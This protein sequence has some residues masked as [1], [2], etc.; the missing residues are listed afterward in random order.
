MSYS[1]NIGTYFSVFGSTGSALEEA[2]VENIYL[3][4]SG[5]DELYIGG[6]QKY[7]PPC[8]TLKDFVIN[9]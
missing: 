6:I 3:D 5:T 7:Y 8:G 2:F 4:I 1:Q 9:N